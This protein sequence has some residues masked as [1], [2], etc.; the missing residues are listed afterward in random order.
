M[1]IF[2]RGFDEIESL[3][4]QGDATIKDIKVRLSKH[5]WESGILLVKCGHWELV[6]VA[7]RRLPLS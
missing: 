3:E 2:V 7:V 1:Q 4:V 6:V 5:D